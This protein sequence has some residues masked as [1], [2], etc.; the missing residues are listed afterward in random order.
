MSETSYQEFELFAAYKISIE[1]PSGWEIQIKALKRNQGVVSF[2][3]KN[4]ECL[5]TL[6]WG[7]LK[8]IQKKF[9]DPEE[10]AQSVIDGFKEKS[11]IKDF[12]LLEKRRLTING[13][14]AAMLRVKAKLKL[15]SLLSRTWLSSN[16]Q[17]FYLYCDETERYLIVYALSPPQ[18]DDY[19][20]IFSHMV[21]SIKCH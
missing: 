7:P 13:H 16:I 3:S 8:N 17:A 14:E 12:T 21:Q 1:Y 6:T 2:K 18:E 19:L 9:G 20:N 5:C 15:G 4:E 10:Q 11:G